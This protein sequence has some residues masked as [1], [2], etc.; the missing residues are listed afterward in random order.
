MNGLNLRQVDGHVV[1]AKT[2]RTAWYVLAPQRSSFLPEPVFDGVVVGGALRLAELVGHRMH[3][4][5]T[6]QPYEVDEWANALNADTHRPLPGWGEFLAEQ[7]EHLAGKNLSEK[8]PLLGVS[9]NVLAKRAKEAAEELA[10][11]DAIV[12]GYGLAGRPATPFEMRYMLRRS[13]ALGLPA[14]RGL[15]ATDQI[16]TSD[17]PELTDDVTWSAEP[18]ARSVRVQ[19]ECDGDLTVRHVVILTTGQM[20]PLDIPNRLDPWLQIPD[21]CPFPVEITSTIDVLSTEVA[22]RGYTVALDTVRSQVTHYAG[23]REVPRRLFRQRE[24]ALQAEERVSSSHDGLGTRTHGWY[25][26]M[27]AGETETEALDR[28]RH[29]TDLYAPTISLVRPAGQF[30]LAQE[31]IPGQVRVHR[32]AA[33]MRDMAVTQVAAAMPQATAEIGDRG[34]FY[35]GETCGVSRHAATWA[36]WKAMEVNER[37]GLTVVAGGLGAGKSMFAA[38]LVYWAV[39]AGVLTY[40]LDP[41]GP[42]GRLTD[43]PELAEHSRLINV[44]DAE[45]GSLSPYRVVPTPIRRHYDSEGEWTRAVALAEGDR[46]TMCADVLAC[47][48]P[49]AIIDVPEMLMALRTA[50]HK[51]GG[52]ATSSAWQVVEALGH[53]DGTLAEPGRYLVGEYTR[54]ANTPQAQLIFPAGY[55]LDSSDHRASATL[56]VLTLRG[57]VT[58]QPGSDRHTWS[59]AQQ[60][61]IAH[62]TLTASLV[63]R[64][65]FEAEMGLRKLAVFDELHALSSIPSGKALIDSTARGSRK[66]NVRALML[67]QL[68]SDLPEGVGE[69]VDSIVGGRTTHSAAQAD[70][71][72]ALGLPGGNGYETVLARLSPQDWRAGA[73]SGFR[74]FLWGYDGATEKIRPDLSGLPGLMGNQDTTPAQVTEINAVRGVA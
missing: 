44:L 66:H 73:R 61:G 53:L 36:P 22:L 49:A 19:G 23:S 64:R 37:S 67:S 41:G 60:F 63:R 14:P 54:L 46:I 3:H 29:L 18:L 7:S 11:I 32:K 65:L 26:F 8:L 31:F 4:R 55:Q 50:V 21:K 24:Q 1:T 9:L 15:L 13:V 59:Q 57:L 48:L 25:R 71:L 68:V 12:A 72:D 40:V 28:A 30:A 42:L 43:L 10:R 69:F 2:G 70:L 52:R 20:R 34:G 56:T 45:P 6:H 47:L 51:V 74:E 35:L 5:V 62:L 58:P 17:L 16:P 33:H 38:L 27:V 39:R